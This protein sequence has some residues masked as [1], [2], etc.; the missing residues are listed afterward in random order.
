MDALYYVKEERSAETE[1]DHETG[2]RTDRC[3]SARSL[4]R[5][6]ARSA[7]NDASAF[8]AFGQQCGIVD[9]VLVAAWPDNCAASIS[10]LASD[11]ER[12]RKPGA[13][14]G[15]GGANNRNVRRISA[16]LFDCGWGCLFRCSTDYGRNSGN[17]DPGGEYEF[18]EQQQWW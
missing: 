16:E 11:R 5:D 9:G 6:Q 2:N 13:P 18:K 3:H 12:C 8:C 17:S 14:K 4:A 7:E 10:R 1:Y 15:R